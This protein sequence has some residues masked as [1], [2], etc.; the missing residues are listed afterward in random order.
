MGEFVRLLLA[1]S[2]KSASIAR[3]IRAEEELFKLLVE[4]KKDGDKNARFLHDFKT[5]ADVLIQE[6]LRHDITKSVS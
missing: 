5:L 4:E 2:E 6:S 3:I 1:A